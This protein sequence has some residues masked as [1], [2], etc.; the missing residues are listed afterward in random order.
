MIVLLATWAELEGGPGEII[1]GLDVHRRQITY[2]WIDTD[3]GQTRQGQLAP[4]S[5]GAPAE[6]AG[7]VRRPAGRVRAGGLYRLA[8]CG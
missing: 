5:R 6:L 1:G 8:V 2:D 3:T 4:A 7:A